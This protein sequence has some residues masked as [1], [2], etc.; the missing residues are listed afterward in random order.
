MIV[1]IEISRPCQI[2][3]WRYSSSIIWRCGWLWVAFGWLR[4]PFDEFAQTS[5]NWEF[6]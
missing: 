1:F 2:S 6:R 5:Y 4:V 3:P